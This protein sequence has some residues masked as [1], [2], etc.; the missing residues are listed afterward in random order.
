MGERA[1]EGKANGEGKSMWKRYKSNWRRVGRLC[2]PINWEVP[3][4]VVL[5]LLIVHF[6]WKTESF[7]RSPSSFTQAFSWHE[8]R[9][10]SLKFLI[11]VGPI[12][13]SNHPN[14][15]KPRVKA[16]NSSLR[17]L[18]RVPTQIWV[19]NCLEILHGNL[20]LPQ[21]FSGYWWQNFLRSW[22]PLSV[23]SHAG[24]DQVYRSQA[25]SSSWWADVWLVVVWPG[26][27]SRLGGFS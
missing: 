16:N 18:R 25:R 9:N 4:E 17:F 23:D 21:P 13:R 15:R 3:Y 26:G 27:D 6:S 2:D 22:R 20:R 19:G 5:V 24:S 10:E 7:L 11:F 14:S 1:R 12:P 8:T